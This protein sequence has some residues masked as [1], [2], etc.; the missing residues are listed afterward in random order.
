[1]ETTRIDLRAPQTTAT[2][3]KV[4]LKNLKSYTY[5]ATTGL[6]V[7]QTLMDPEDGCS[8]SGENEIQERPETREECEADSQQGQR[9]GDQKK[10]DNTEWDCEFCGEPV[11]YGDWV[12]SCGNKCGHLKCAEKMNEHP[13]S[14]VS[15]ATDDQL[16]R[17]LRDLKE[18]EDP[19]CN[20]KKGTFVLDTSLWDEKQKRYDNF[21]EF[22]S[23]K[24]KVEVKLI[25][26][27]K[28]KV[29]KDKKDQRCSLRRPK[30]LPQTNRNG[31][32][33]QRNSSLD[34]K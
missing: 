10:E 13:P 17:H 34:E 3:G 12:D 33:T 28:G 15:L 21:A 7:S 23:K 32:S 24:R 29:G 19:V 22:Q 14:N 8:S 1:M 16:R 26:S 18:G 6:R 20:V 25:T 27:K 31:K 11:Y 30:A 5:P 2:S 9:D 4:S